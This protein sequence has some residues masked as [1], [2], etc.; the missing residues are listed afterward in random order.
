MEKFSEFTHKLSQNSLALLR[1][2]PSHPD[3]FSI[4]FGDLAFMI[5]DRKYQTTLGGGSTFI[6][7]ISTT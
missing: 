7:S 2:K 1:I 6:P 4:Q 3:C 5:Q